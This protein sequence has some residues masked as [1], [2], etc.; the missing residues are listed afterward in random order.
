MFDEGDPQNSQKRHK[1]WKTHQKAKFEFELQTQY[2]AK[3]FD[4]LQQYENVLLACENHSSQVCTS[5]P[6]AQIQGQ[7]SKR[8]IITSFPK[9]IWTDEQDHKKHCTEKWK[10]KISYNTGG[11]FFF[12]AGGLGGLS[13]QPPEE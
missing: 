12:V 10:A 4:Q 8:P 3:T 11:D 6:G 1:V 2:H 5:P 7:I 9:L 13:R